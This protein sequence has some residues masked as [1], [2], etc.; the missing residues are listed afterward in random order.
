MTLLAIRYRS[1]SCKHGLIN[2]QPCHTDITVFKQLQLLNREILDVGQAELVVSRICAQLVD[3]QTA[4]HGYRGFLTGS[5]RNIPIPRKLS[6]VDTEIFCR[7]QHREAVA[8]EFTLHTDICITAPCSRLHT[9]RAS[10][11]LLGITQLHLLVGNGQ[12]LA[13]KDAL[14]IK[15]KP[16]RL[17]TVGQCNVTLPLQTGI[18]QTPAILLQCQLIHTN[19]AGM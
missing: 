9:K 14:Q 10:P 2:R 4:C 12:V 15:R 13:G 18:T 11:L 17:A 6:M 5:N 19:L 1:I 3:P 16:S 8:I 7:Y